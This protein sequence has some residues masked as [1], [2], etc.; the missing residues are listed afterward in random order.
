MHSTMIIPSK[1]G[2]Y[3][4]VLTAAETATIRIGRLGDLAVIPG[5]YLY[6]GS[7]LGTGGLAGRLR[8]HTGFV[9]RPHWHVD[10]LRT[11][12]EL[13]AI[14]WLVAPAR[15]EHTWALALAQTPGCSVPMPRFGAS[16][17]HCL[18]HLFYLPTAPSALADGPAA[19]PGILPTLNMLLTRTSAGFNPTGTD[20]MY[21]LP[22]AG[23]HCPLTEAVSRQE[24][25]EES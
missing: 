25:N 24:R 6:V 9:D 5:Y 21:D 12:T 18:A 4:L 13:C 10:Y 20:S 16:D 22:V 3:V 7:A 14:G 1:P 11:A 8:H 2:S 15:M 17:C 19:M 23:A